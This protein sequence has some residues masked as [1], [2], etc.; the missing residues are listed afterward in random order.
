LRG[1]NI[2]KTFYGLTPEF[3]M[4]FSDIRKK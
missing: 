1:A 2:T 3:L 4:R